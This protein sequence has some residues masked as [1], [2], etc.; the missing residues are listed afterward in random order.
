[1]AALVVA[2]LGLGL[3]WHY[4]GLA[5]IGAALTAIVVLDAVSLARAQRLDVRRT[6]EPVEVSRRGTCT[7]RLSVRSGGSTVRAEGT[8]R[9]GGVSIEIPLGRIESGGAEVTYPVPTDRRGRLEVGP[10]VVR[11]YGLAGLTVSAG[12]AG[13][14]TFVRVLPRALPVRAVPP[15]ARHGHV[16]AEERA[17]RGGTDVI[18]LREYQPGDDL[19]RVHW[20]TSARAGTLMVREDAD[21]VRAHLTVVLDDRASS[22]EHAEAFEEAV[23]VAASLLSAA[24]A[25]GHPVRLRMVHSGLDLASGGA[26]SGDHI[27]DIMVAL[28]DASLVDGAGE[29]HSTPDD[30]DVVAVVTGAAAD[31]TALTSAS[32]RAGAGAVL[33]VGSGAAAPEPD[34]VPVLYAP[35]AED[36]LGAWDALVSSRVVAA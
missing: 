35:S 19:R 13:D 5:A 1:V 34:R 11:R 28:V 17:V 4:P 6:I 20:G 30:L 31:V 14:E 15:G 25:E 3:R 33:A 7:A 23:D 24:G 10:V 26:G 22:Y 8:D 36:L 32:A 27:D 29:A 21:P 12:A 18:G 9:V 16:G 2:C